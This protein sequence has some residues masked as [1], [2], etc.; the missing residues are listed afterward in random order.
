MSEE[1]NRA[2][3]DQYMLRLPDGMRDR[4]KASAE[5]N[6][7]SMNAEIV[8]VLQKAFPDDPA[9][10][11]IL[12]QWVA[13]IAA[14]PTREDMD[15]V[16]REGNLALRSTPLGKSFGLGVMSVPYYRPDEMV[17][18]PAVFAITH[19][20]DGKPRARL[21]WWVPTQVPSPPKPGDK[22]SD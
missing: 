7:R 22:A 18:G 17:A 8:S 11:P 1:S 13:R 20:A 10:H 16:S 3:K 6:G 9:K 4:I 19:D 21:E 5:A 15:R 2:W 14:Q 12:Q